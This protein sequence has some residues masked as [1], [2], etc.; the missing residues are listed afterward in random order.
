M[1]VIGLVTEYNP[2]HNGHK[3]HLEKSK[4]LSGASHSIAVM[5]GNFLQR[6]EPALFDKWE[7]AKIAVNEGIDLVI[8]LPTIF[9]CNSAEFFAQGSITLLDSLNIVNFICFGSEDGKLE[10][11]DLI[12][13]LLINEPLEYKEILKKYLDLGYT[14]PLA[15]QNALEEYLGNSLAPTN[16]LNSPNNILGIE[17]IKALKLLN[18]SIEPLTIKRIKADYNSKKIEDN[19]CSATA[20]RSLLQEDYSDLMGVKKVVPFKSF[21][22]IK[23]I[24]E[25]GRGPIF[26]KDLE[27]IILYKLRME[28]PYELS[29]IHDVVEGLENR[30]KNG[31]MRST[32]YTELMEYLKT[33]RYTMT[34]LQRIL[35]KTILGIS[36]D[37]V[38]VLVKGLGPQ[39]IRVLGFNSKGADL[40]RM[41]KK[42]SKLPIITNLKR[43]NPPNENVKRMLDIDITASDVYSLLY[44]NGKLAIGGLDYITKPFIAN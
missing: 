5:S 36:K 30:L 16:I 34:R 4:E 13:E 37:D 7:R 6:G 14:F 10:N 39:Y 32:S 33:K 9:S 12:S 8:E 1:K 35:I 2:F 25:E 44:K 11:I 42:Q 17:Y 18:S 3:Y 40:L 24:I 41:I 21:N 27:Q 20:I 28:S 29:H 19:I 26:S 23:N 22:I 43:F 15:R 38:A 31:S